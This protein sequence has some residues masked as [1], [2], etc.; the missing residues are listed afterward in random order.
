[1][2][3]R[4]TLTRIAS[5]SFVAFVAAGLA[6][7]GSAPTVAQNPAATAAQE[8]TT[9]QETTTAQAQDGG[10]ARVRFAHLS[11]DA[12][13]VDVLVDNRTVE[14][15]LELGDVT[16]YRAVPAGERQITI[17]AANDTSRVV[18][19]G[20][21]NLE[22]GTNYTI[23]A[24]G[25]IAENATERFRPIALTEDPQV[26]SGGNASVR[27]VHLSPDAGPVDVTVNETGRVLYDN[28]TFG[29]ATDYVTVPSGVYTLDVRRATRGDNGTVV[30]SVDVSFENRMA[31]TAFAAGYVS[32]ED[33]PANESFRVVTAIDAT[34]NPELAPETTTETT[35]R[36]VEATTE[37]EANETTTAA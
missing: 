16:E 1:M 7:G 27:F 29:N 13:A 9:V 26:P 4:Q 33:A 18:F 11:P 19:Q 25:E 2:V 32:P 12:P 10:Q 30:E 37:A 20:E 6:L 28:A 22:A 21:L 36:A 15:D 5:L 34:N 8:T 14:R 17:R 3:E 23:A 24:A 31:Y 35:A